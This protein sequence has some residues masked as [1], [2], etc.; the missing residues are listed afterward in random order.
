MGMIVFW[1]IVAIGVIVLDLFTSSFLFMWFSIGA[2]SAIVAEIFGLNWGWQILVF[3]VIS[4]I[5]ISL[6]YPLV[7]RQFKKSLKRTPLMEENYIGMNIIA[8]KDII[9]KA[10]VKV[11]GIYWTVVNSGDKI[12]KGELFQII[13]IKGTKLEIKK[14]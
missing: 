10:V 8:E 13:E 3:S 4:I 12:M 11:E 1:I 9:D 5:S 2:I 6:G 14:V 7:K